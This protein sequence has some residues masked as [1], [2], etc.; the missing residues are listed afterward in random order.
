MPTNPQ[1]TT[2]LEDNV[3]TTTNVGAVA[4]T[5]NDIQ[6]AETENTEKEIENLTANTESEESSP[7]PEASDLESEN[8]DITASTNQE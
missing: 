8:V 1:S 3:L 2:P 4:A 7:A 5:N 6:E